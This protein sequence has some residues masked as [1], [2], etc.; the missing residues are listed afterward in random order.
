V[1]QFDRLAAGLDYPV[2]VVTACAGG[3]RAGCLVG[4][5]TQCSMNPPVRFVVCISRRNHSHRVASQA[6]HLAVHVV[7]ADRRDVAELFGTR[8]GDD[9]DKF[10]ACDWEPGPGG[11]PLLAACP[12]RFVGRVVGRFDGGDHEGFVLEVVEAWADDDV[13][14][15]TF[16]AARDLDPG[17][18]A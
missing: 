8:T 3:E 2:F 11:T 18:P 16:H 10:S 14:P 9:T 1:G 15:M 7:P 5:T 13:R 12:S 4:F 6:D 17:H